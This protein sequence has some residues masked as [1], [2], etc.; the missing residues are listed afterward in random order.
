MQ[1]YGRVNEGNGKSVQKPATE[2]TG[3]KGKIEVTPGVPVGSLRCSMLEQLASS[4]C[5]VSHFDCIELSSCSS[6]LLSGLVSAN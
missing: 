1:V 4:A 6:F 3:E 2:E 5:V